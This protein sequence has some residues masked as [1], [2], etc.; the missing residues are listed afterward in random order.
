MNELE[1]PSIEAH[2]LTV[3]YHRKPVLWNIDFFLPQG[4]IIG[5]MGPNGA[6]KST[7]IKAILGLVPLNSGYSRKKEINIA[8]DWFTVVEDR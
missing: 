3:I 6:G 5:I 8:Q 7:L 2:N 4:Q 1:N